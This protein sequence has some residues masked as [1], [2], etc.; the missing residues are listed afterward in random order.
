M[1][2]Y[3]IRNEEISKIQNIINNC[4][5]SSST[6]NIYGSSGT[7]KT[8]LIKKTIGKYFVNKS[9]STIIYINLLDDILW[10]TAFWDMIL[11]TVW[12]GNICDNT[13]MIKIDRKNSMAYYLKR[14]VRGRKIFKT[15]LNSI[16]SIVATIPV[17]NAQLEVGGWE[18]IYQILLLTLIQK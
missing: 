1:N 6:I 4:E 14:S 8:F 16:T 9:G 2:D 5:K 17:Y 12:N 10:T 7:G 15:L 3:N 11:F 13:N 18:I